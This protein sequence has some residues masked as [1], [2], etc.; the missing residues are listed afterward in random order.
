MV[1]APLRVP[2][3]L[4]GVHELKI[5]FIIILTYILPFSHSLCHACA[6]NSANGNGTCYHNLLSADADMNAPLSSNRPDVKEIG[7]NVTEF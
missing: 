3:G 6:M 5:I 4:S 1:Q 7:K 2:K